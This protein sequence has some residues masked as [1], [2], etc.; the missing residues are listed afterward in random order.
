VIPDAV[1]TDHHQPY[2][3]AVAT[4]IPLARQVRTGLHRRCGYTTQPVDRSHGPTR[5]RLRGARGVRTVPTGQKFLEGFEAL[6]AL[7][8]DT[9]KLRALVPGYQ[10]TRASMHERARAV[11]AAREV[12]GAQFKK[13]A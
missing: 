3:K 6:H 8:R 10:P 1:I 9:I 5:D 12:L 13:A 2:G 4:I 7:R 11:V